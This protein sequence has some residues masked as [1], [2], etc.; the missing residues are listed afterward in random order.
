MGHTGLVAEEGGKVDGL[1][2]VILGEGLALSTVPPSPLAGQ[3]S[4]GT[5]TGVFKLTV[6]L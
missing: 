5:G 6:R 4:Q 2:F 1:R 3:E